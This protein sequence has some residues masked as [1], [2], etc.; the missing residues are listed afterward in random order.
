MRQNE[1]KPTFYSCTRETWGK[2]NLPNGL[3]TESGPRFC[4]VLKHF[5]ANLQATFGP[6]IEIVQK[7]VR[8]VYARSF[9]TFMRALLRAPAVRVAFLSR[10]V[11][12]SSSSS[13]LSFSYFECFQ[14][15]SNALFQ[16][17]LKSINQTSIDLIEEERNTCENKTI[18]TWKLVIVR[19]KIRCFWKLQ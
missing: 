15:F 1:R 2:R 14:I 16:I 8:H 17:R 13:I 10:L 11:A 3:S 12:H 7:L 6:E 5:L 9:G 19:K 18:H 4:R